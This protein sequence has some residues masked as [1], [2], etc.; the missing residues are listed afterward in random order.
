[1]VYPRLGVL[2]NVI[3]MKQEVEIQPTFHQDELVTWHDYQGQKCI[4][5]PGVVVSQD[6]ESVL[7]RTRVKGLTQELRVSPKMLVHR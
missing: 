3:E 6:R 2:K 1:M 4:P 7:I 5:I